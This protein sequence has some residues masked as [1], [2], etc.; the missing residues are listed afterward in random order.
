[1]RVPP[2]PSHRMHG[3]APTIASA[4]APARRP[5]RRVV[6]SAS[7]LT[8]IVSAPASALVAALAAWA[9]TSRLSL[10]AGLAAALAA[11]LGGAAAG[12]PVWWSL[13]RAA[14]LP[15]PASARPVLGRSDQAS[16]FIDAAVREIARARRHGHGAA[17]LLVELDR[18]ANAGAR[19]RGAADDAA[20]EA[21][22]RQVAPTLRGADLLARFSRAQLAVLLSPAD[23]TGALDVA[24]RIREM[25]EQT[26]LPGVGVGHRQ[27]VT[28]SVG[29]A[30]L[31]PM[32]ANLALLIE[33]TTDALA[34]AREAGG[35][36]V[37]AAPVGGSRL[38]LS[39]PR[40]GRRTQ[41]K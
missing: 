21:L 14:G 1:M 6:V 8:A 3:A 30:L 11:A 33:D 5:A 28:V 41:P 13:R 25:A 35:N 19:D 20:V 7:L 16:R 17:M 29:A 4:P 32:P 34:L 24:E 26:E 9:W 36:C 38:R 39:G 31:R 10:P 18:G 37:R 2:S 40:D 23:A 22:L 15:S 27:R 12:L